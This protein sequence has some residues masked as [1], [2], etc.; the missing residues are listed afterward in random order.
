MED[1]KYYTK[2][3][4]IFFKQTKSKKQKEIPPTP[5]INQTHSHK[6]TKGPW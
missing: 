4:I 5:P 1:K 2:L 3:G 6:H